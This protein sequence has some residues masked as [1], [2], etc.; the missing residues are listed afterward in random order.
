MVI[1]SLG[2]L[3]ALLNGASFAEAVR[4]DPP[5]QRRSRRTSRRVA[6]KAQYPSLSDWFP[7]VNPHARL[8]AG[9]AAGG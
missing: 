6:K 1:R 3:T 8:L 9:A 4:L 5:E 2:R 7:A